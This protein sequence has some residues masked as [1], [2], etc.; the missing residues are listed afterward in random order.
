MECYPLG[1]YMPN[2]K[3]GAMKQIRTLDTWHLYWQTNT[4][5]LK[6]KKRYTTQFSSKLRAINAKHRYKQQKKKKTKG[7]TMTIE[8]RYTDE[9]TKYN[10]KG[11]SLKWHNQG[12]GWS[13]TN[14]TIH[15]E[16]TSHMVMS[17]CTAAIRQSSIENIHSKNCGKQAGCRPRKMWME[18]ITETFNITLYKVKRRALPRL[19]FVSSIV[20]GVRGRRQDKTRLENTV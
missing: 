8:M 15:P 11:P 13:N 17:T 20:K 14:I 7:K 9:K 10:K 18:K 3:M 4:T 6:Q 19:Q 12:K 5:H 1:K 2:L 16:T